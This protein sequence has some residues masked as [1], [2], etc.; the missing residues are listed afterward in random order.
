MKQLY[1]LSALLLVVLLTSMMLKEKNVSQKSSLASMGESQPMF[2]KG[3][4][5]IKVN[6]GIGEYEYKKV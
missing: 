4:I 3:M 6:E 2:L 5:T 1:I